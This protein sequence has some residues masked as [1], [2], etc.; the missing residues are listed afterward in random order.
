MASKQNTMYSAS[1]SLV[2][3]A[4]FVGGAATY[5]AFGIFVRGVYEPK[6]GGPWDNFV[7]LVSLG[8]QASIPLV[9]G[10]FLVVALW[11]SRVG[12]P[13]AAAWV[14]GTVTAI[15]GLLSFYLGPLTTI[16][17]LIRGGSGVF[18]K[19]ADAELLSA[20]L[21]V[22]VL[23]CIVGLTSLLLLHATQGRR[24]D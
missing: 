16:H 14:T 23:G 13:R 18:S 7:T 12:M 15:L 1:A 21:S 6:L 19:H 3:L 22:V 24:S 11:V 8:F 20:G 10:V 5:N 4:V 17:G 9:I 2:T